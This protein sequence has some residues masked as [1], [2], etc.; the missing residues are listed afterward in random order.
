MGNF[1]NIQITLNSADALSDILAAG[2]ERSGAIISW[3]GNSNSVSFGKNASNITEI[4]FT[5]EPAAPVST[6]IIDNGDDTYT[7]DWGTEM[8]VLAT[9]NTGY[10]VASWSNGADVNDLVV[11]TQTLTVTGELSIAA[12]FAANPVI[13]LGS[14]DS[15]FGVVVID[16]L[17]AISGLVEL[18]N[19]SYSVLPG[20]E[21]TLVAVPAE[22]YHL[23]SWSNGAAV[24]TDNNQ[25]VTV[26]DETGISAFF[27]HDT[28]ILTV[29]GA[30][31]KTAKFADG[32]DAA[33]VINP[34][35]LVGVVEGDSVKL[36]TTATYSSANVGDNLTITL[37]YAIEVIEDGIY[38]NEYALAI[39]DSIYPVKGAI[40]EPMTPDEKKTPEEQE[41]DNK[42]GFEIYAYCYC[43]GDQVGFRFHLTSGNPD[44]YKIDF[45]DSRFTDIDWTDLDISGKDGEVFIDIP[46]DMPTGDY[47][48][49][50]TFRDSRYDWLES[51]PLPVTFHVNLPETYVVAL[52]DNV[53]AIVD[54]CECLT[55]IQWYHRNNA[56]E[57][58]TLIEGATGYYYK[59]EGGVT[60]EYFIKAKMNG[61][62]TYTCPQDDLTLYGGNKKAKVS[63]YPNPVRSTTT[64]TI[65]DSDNYEHTLRIINLMGNEMMSTSFEG[66]TTTVDMDGY[67]IGNY[68]ISVDGIAVKVM[69]Q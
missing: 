14:N 3:T 6:G 45:A 17:N 38:D 11:A 69:K 5:I 8:T 66:N 60:G 1:T 19:D 40:I 21:L 49:T 37:H 32:T 39:T 48:M 56:S 63:A 51:N 27:K 22:D 42:E 67:T 46:M 2:W 23:L 53:M 61:V 29:E 47:Q 36:T 68:I 15:N 31:V 4:A 44:Q 57:P 9:A 64:V 7:V 58:W 30:E 54:T 13:T 24:N 10:H 12:A 35:T 52:F 16:S 20:T 59:Q 18:G 28:Y 25:T 65:E 43:R 55:D 26:N 41:A 62:D 33:V 34:G 50:V